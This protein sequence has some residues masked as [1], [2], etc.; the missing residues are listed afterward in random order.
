MPSK[1]ADAGSPL[2]PKALPP[3][4]LDA[5]LRKVFHSVRQNWPAMLGLE[6][7]MA[8]VVAIYY[9]W[10]PGAEV[11]SKYAAWQH[12]GGPFATA[13]ASGLAGGVLSELSLVYLQ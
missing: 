5:A 8:G 6:L 1:P 9:T 13:L 12:S 11:I 10:P 7:A 3:S 2:R 4:P